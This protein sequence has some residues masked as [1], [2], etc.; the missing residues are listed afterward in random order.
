MPTYLDSYSMGYAQVWIKYS[1]ET[2]I[3]LMAS[4]HLCSYR[5]YQLQAL[6]SAFGT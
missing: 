6:P 3:I 2:D 5:S 1:L 4:R